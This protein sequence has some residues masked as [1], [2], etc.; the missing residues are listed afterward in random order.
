MATKRKDFKFKGGPDDFNIDDLSIKKVHSIIDEI[1]V[2]RG[3]KKIS[4]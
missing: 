2:L 1:G 3:W 4:R